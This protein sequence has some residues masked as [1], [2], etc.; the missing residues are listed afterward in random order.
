VGELNSHII[1]VTFPDNTVY[2]FRPVLNISGLNSSN[3]QQFVPIDQ[4]QGGTVSFTALAGTTATITTVV[5]FDL[6]DSGGVGPFNLDDID[7]N[8]IDLT[9]LTLKLTDGSTYNVSLSAGLTSAQ[10]PNG[11]T[12]NIGPNGITHSTGR[13]VAFTRDLSN[14]I[15]QIADPLGNK[16]KYAYDLNGNLGSST[17][18]GNNTTTYQYN[19]THGL[20]QINDPRGLQPIR[21]VYDD[22]GRLIQ[23]VDS[24][25]HVTNYSQNLGLRQDIVTNRLGRATVFGYDDYGNVTSEQ[26]QLGNSPREPTTR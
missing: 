21:N 17:D 10:D 23:Q 16:L 1:S 4:L 25:G 13:S 14:R 18:R 8:T 9:T 11:N 5:P 24:F 26:N 6:F 3:C 19:V 12:I 15:T 22:S 20:L 7:F 2:K